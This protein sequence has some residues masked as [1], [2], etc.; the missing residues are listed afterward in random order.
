M[1]GPRE[2]VMS[3]DTIAVLVAAAVILGFLWNIHRDMAGIHRNMA[4]IHRDMSELRERMARLEGSLDVLTK[5]LMG[6]ER[7]ER[8]AP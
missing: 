4:G 7:P 6:R 8:E 2:R 1:T 3:V 5:F